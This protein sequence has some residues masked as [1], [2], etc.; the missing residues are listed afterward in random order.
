MM[1]LSESWCY[2]EM[3]EEEVIIYREG[4][5]EQDEAKGGEEDEGSLTARPPHTHH[6]EG[7]HKQTDGVQF[8]LTLPPL[9]T[10]HLDTGVEN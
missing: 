8:D 7:L 10:P 2:L 1:I 6:S 5:L 4:G 3:Y 9:L